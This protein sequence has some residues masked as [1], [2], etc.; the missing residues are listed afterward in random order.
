[1]TA[2]VEGVTE[3]KKC[4]LFWCSDGTCQ[5]SSSLVH[6]YKNVTSNKIAKKKNWNIKTALLVTLDYK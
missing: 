4:G 2:H 5:F 6:I 3:F 1:M